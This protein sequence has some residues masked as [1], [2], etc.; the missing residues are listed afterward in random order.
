MAMEGWGAIVT[1]VTSSGPASTGSTPILPSDVLVALGGMPVTTV[2]SAHAIAMGWPQG[3]ALCASVLREGRLISPIW[4]RS[5]G[6]GSPFY[7]S[8]AAT[9]MGCEV[10]TKPSEAELED[11]S[12]HMVAQQRRMRA[13][14]EH[15]EA[16]R[17]E[18]LE[19][20]SG[21]SEPW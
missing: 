19:A 1:R 6:G 9:G 10:G 2:A 8:R 12:K 15:L 5:A 7:G 14:E 16:S 21:L 20:S 13:R 3:Q 17:K 4:L 11:A 18:H